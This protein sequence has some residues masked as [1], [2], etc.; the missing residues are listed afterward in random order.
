MPNNMDNE[1]K[2]SLKR[3]LHYEGSAFQEW[4]HK[5]KNAKI[6]KRKSILLKQYGNCILNSLFE[7]ANKY[8]I[9]MWIEFGTLLGAYREHGFIKHDFDLDVGMYKA[10]YTME[11]ENELYKKGF[12]KIRSFYIESVS[13][14]EETMTEV[15]FDYQGLQLDIFFNH[16][17]GNSRYAYYYIEH[18]KLNT[19]NKVYGVVKLK[20]PQVKGLSL[21]A[22]GNCNYPS[23]ANVEE[24]LE[25]YYGKNF[26]TPIKDYVIPEDDP[27][28]ENLS[29]DNYRGLM[30]GFWNLF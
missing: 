8:D 16:N 2:D 5:K 1:L 29:F 17:D 22:I 13:S 28:T 15:T 11:F 6:F 3:A 7:V 21:L 27:C 9:P 26:M 23:P 25:A 10:D 20:Y 24:V 4:R 14:T 30:K 12:I 19:K 18:D